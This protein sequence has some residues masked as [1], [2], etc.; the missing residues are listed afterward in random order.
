MRSGVVGNMG[1]RDV[2]SRNQGLENI[3]GEIRLHNEH[4]AFELLSDEWQKQV[5]RNATTAGKGL[6]SSTSGTFRP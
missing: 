3:E 5:M 1:Y 4:G 2:S 6:K